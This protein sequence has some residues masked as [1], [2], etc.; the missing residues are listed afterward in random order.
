MKKI[1]I[2]ILVILLLIG[3]GFAALKLSGNWGRFVLLHHLQELTTEEYSFTA[4][5]NTGEIQDIII[6]GTYSDGDISA[7]VSI[8]GSEMADIYHSAEG[9]TVY[10]IMPAVNSIAAEVDSILPFGLSV[11]SLLPEQV[12]INQEQLNEL[13]GST[14]LTELTS[15]FEGIEPWQAVLALKTDR[16]IPES[17]ALLGKDGI[18]YYRISIEGAEVVIGIPESFSDRRVS[19]RAVTEEETVQI[20]FSYEETEVEEFVMPEVTV[21]DETISTLKQLYEYWQNLGEIA[22]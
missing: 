3:G 15:S 11:S 12:T 20:V 7:A 14:D 21:S 6:N 17:E 5:V 13:I 16:N 4:Q 10:D 18:C 8:S 9:E 1:L 19:V 2:A 22:S